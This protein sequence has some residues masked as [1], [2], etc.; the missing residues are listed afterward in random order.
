MKPDELLDIE[1][2]SLRRGLAAVGRKTRVYTPP[3]ALHNCG[4]RAP[5]RKGA[6]VPAEESHAAGRERWRALAASGLVDQR[7]LDAQRRA[8]TRRARQAHR[9]SDRLDTIPQA[10]QSR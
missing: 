2:S 9:P 3:R 1:A 4:S 10:E 6:G 7:Q 8:R 5:P